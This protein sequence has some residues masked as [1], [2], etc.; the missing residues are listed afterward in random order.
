MRCSCGGQ[1]R[2]ITIKMADL[3]QALASRPFSSVMTLLASGN[4]VLA[5]ELSPF[6]V[7]GEFE[8]CLRDTFGYDAW[9]IVLS[10]ERVGELVEACPY[11]QR[12][13]HPRLPDTRPER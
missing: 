4:L 12:H 13:I 7:K 9:L 1:R 8:V 2:R 3:K 10:A 11:P 6:G 5:S